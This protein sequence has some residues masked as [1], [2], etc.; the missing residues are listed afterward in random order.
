MRIMQRRGERKREMNKNK[1]WGERDMNKGGGER[2][3]NVFTLD[4]CYILLMPSVP[5]QST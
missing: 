2:D 4:A 3:M 1:K 5:A